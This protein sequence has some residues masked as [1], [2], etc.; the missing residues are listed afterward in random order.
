M[1]R[2]SMLAVLMAAVVAAGGL[3]AGCGDETGEGTVSLQ[4][5]G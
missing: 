3:L 1:K 4:Q 5:T 2:I